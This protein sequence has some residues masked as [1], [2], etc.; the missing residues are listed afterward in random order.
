M[1]LTVQS[2]ELISQ[3]CIQNKELKDVR[4]K[5]KS[6]FFG[7]DEPGTINYLG[8]AEELNPRERRFM[9]WFSFYFRLPEGRHPAE[10]VAET[11]WKGVELTEALKSIQSARYIMAIVSMVITGKEVF[12]KLED[13]EF[14]INSGYLSQGVQKDDVVCAH[15][16]PGARNRWILGP[17]WL[18]WPTRFGPGIRAK[19]KDFQLNPVQVERVLQQKDDGKEKPWKKYPQDKTLVDA[20][21]R[22]T[23]TA[24]EAGKEQLIHSR[25][26]WTNLVLKYMK[27]NTFL[28]LSK[29]IT[30]WVGPVA[31]IDELNK[32]IALATNIWNNV[33]QPDRG[34]RSA[35]EIQEEL[36]RRYKDTQ[37]K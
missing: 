12:L 31:S 35:N 9:G 14:E 34:N 1:A 18:T 17:G 2:I 21:N 28:Q 29:D 5:A 11:I 24:K 33:P 13:E 32:W 19:L 6:E 30:N 8:G 3:L 25:E 10:L 37:G 26:E 22:M 15:I 4:A 23:E 36:T 16:L 7:D 27:A 20:V